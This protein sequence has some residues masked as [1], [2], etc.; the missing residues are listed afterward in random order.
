M[1]LVLFIKVILQT[2]S[3]VYHMTATELIKQKAEDLSSAFYIFGFKL[4]V[5]S[6]NNTG[7]DGTAAF[8]DSETE[9]VLYCNRG[10]QFD[11]HVNVVAGHA[12]LNAFGKGDN[13]GN[14][15]CTEVELRSVVVEERG[16]TAAL[17]L[18]KDV[19]LAMELGVGM[20]GTGLSKNLAALDLVLGDTTEKGA[21][22][23]AGLCVVEELAEHLD[24]GNG[25]LTGLVHKA[26]DLDLIVHLN[27]ATLNSTSSD[28]AASGDGEDVLNRHKEG[29]ILLAVGGLDILVDSVHKIPDALILRS[30]GIGGV[31]LEDAESGALDDGGVVAREVI[32]VEKLADF[33]LNEREELGIVDL[34]NLVKEDNDVRNVNLAGKKKVLAGLSHRTVGSGDNEDSA[35]H[36]SS[37]G[38]HVLDIVG[39]ARAVNVGIVTGSGL[40]LNVSGVDRDTTGALLGSLVDLIVSGVGSGAGV[41]HIQNLGDSGGKGGLAVVDVADGSDVNMGFG[42][43]KFCFSHFG[44]FLLK[45][46][47][48]FKRFYKLILYYH[49]AIC[50]NYFAPRDFIIS[51]LIFFG[52]SVKW[53]GSIE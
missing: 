38:D 7:A 49:A 18:G 12:H 3:L 1:I 40:I 16:V 45:I 52:S 28:G 8:T 43:L 51:S 36:L 34:V 29:H 5:D 50:N 48:S 32:L 4:L 30:V 39:V 24:T 31:G 44:F 26:D 13:A 9:S 35:I 19:D 33:H 17:I 2:F 22:V 6:D 46:I 53:L 15:S 20:N 37:A 11:I 41:G 25:G 10:D 21:D 14:V 47:N 23:V 42:S 27:N